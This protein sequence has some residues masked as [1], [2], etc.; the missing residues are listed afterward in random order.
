MRAIGLI[1]LP[2]SVCLSL[3]ACGSGTPGRLSG[4]TATGAGTGA[5][6]GIIGGPI[7]VVVG[8]AIGGAAGALTSANTTPQ[9]VDLGKPLWDRG[10]S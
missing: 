10:G 5:V 2:L 6:I 7:G 1:I 8:A 9:Q 4:G 3:T